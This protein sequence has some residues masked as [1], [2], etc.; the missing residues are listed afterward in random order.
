[1]DDNENIQ[2]LQFQ[3][4]NHN[5]DMETNI[6]ATPSNTVKQ[7]EDIN[8]IEIGAD[9]RT[10][11]S[12]LIYGIN[13]NPPIA[14][15]VLFAF[16]QTISAVPKCLFIVTLLA[17]VVCATDVENFKTQMFS[18]TI[19]LTG[20]CTF[21]QCTFGVR[22]PVYQ[23]PVTYYILPLLALSALP[24]WK[25]PDSYSVIAKNSSLVNMT[26]RSNF[27]NGDV[28]QNGNTFEEAHVLPKMKVLSG[29]LMLAGIVH[30]LVGMTGVI[31][32]LMRYVGPLTVVPTLI[33]VTIP[34][35]FVLV[36]FCEPSWTVT[37]T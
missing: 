37:L 23:G 12:T 25:C 3:S 35:A 30:M 6:N 24:E 33:L 14:L 15:T 28:T 8:G 19:L 11:Q 5:A 7:Q 10:K 32:M 22:L 20:L 17:E 27:S 1:M 4:G 18:T 36:K 13:D 31:G 2:F 21:F 34:Q 9:V 26:D 29:S 16:Q